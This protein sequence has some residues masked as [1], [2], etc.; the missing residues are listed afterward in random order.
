MD[1][2]HAGSLFVALTASA[3]NYKNSIEHLLLTRVGVETFYY[4]PDDA[5][6]GS[7]DGPK[8]VTEEGG[9]LEDI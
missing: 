1:Q 2:M 3:F 9:S 4:N 7:F 5:S 6:K 8:Y